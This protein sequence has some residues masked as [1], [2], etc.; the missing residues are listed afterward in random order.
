MLFD[1][2]AMVILDLLALFA[3]EVE[4]VHMLVGGVGTSA[5]LECD[6][7]EW[8]RDI[9]FAVLVLIAFPSCFENFDFT[10]GDGVHVIASYDATGGE[11]S[12]SGV[13]EWA[14]C[15]TLVFLGHWVSRDGGERNGGEGEQR[16]EKHVGVI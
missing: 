8:R 9:L 5:L 2:F 16:E 12:V 1:E 3:V 13:K 10:R 15:Y 4:S 14:R 7:G 11:N 6:L